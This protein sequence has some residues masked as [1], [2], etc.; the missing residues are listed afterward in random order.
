MDSQLAT[1]TE[2]ETFCTI[3]KR[4]T[5]SLEAVEGYEMKSVCMLY[6]LAFGQV[7]SGGKV[8]RLAAA[9]PAVSVAESRPLPMSRHPL[10]LDDIQGIHS[11]MS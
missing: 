9:E 7:I 4:C 1:K 10:S 11:E 8:R 3:H 6:R 2:T 5:T